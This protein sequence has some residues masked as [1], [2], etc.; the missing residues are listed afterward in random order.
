[1]KFGAVPEWSHTITLEDFLVILLIMFLKELAFR[2]N[3]LFFSSN[4][5]FLLFW[6]TSD[7]GWHQA[8]NQS[9]ELELFSVFFPVPTCGI[10]SQQLRRLI[11]LLLTK[12]PPDCNG[13]ISAL[14]LFFMRSIRIVQTLGRCSSNVFTIS[15]VYFANFFKR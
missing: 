15:L 11:N 13:R 5:L 7:A 6:S 1:M 14:W 4:S 10:F 8:P 12:L 9:R 2:S 3:I